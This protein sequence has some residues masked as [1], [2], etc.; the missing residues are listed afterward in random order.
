MVK[1][2]PPFNKEQAPRSSKGAYAV[3]VTKRGIVVKKWP[4]KRG[5]STTG[6]DMWR[7]QELA[8]AGSWATNPEPISLVSAIALAKNTDYVPRDILLLAMFGL[9]FEF[10]RI[11]EFHLVPA[12]Y[13]NPNPQY[14]LDMISDVPGAILR[15]DP[16]GW[17]ALLPGVDGEVLSMIEGFPN[18]IPQQAPEAAPLLLASPW[19]GLPNAL[20]LT[21]STSI[22]IT[23]GPGHIISALRAALTGDVTAPSNSNATTIGN[24]V[25]TYA[26][27]QNIGTSQRLLGR[28]AAGP[29]TIEELTL[30]DALDLAGAASQGSL[31]YRD[32]STWQSLGPGTLGQALITQGAGQNPHWATPAS[33]GGIDIQ[34][35]LTPG[36]FTGVSGWNK[37]AGARL[38]EVWVV[39]AGGGGGAGRRGPTTENSA[40]G[41]GGGSAGITWTKF[42]AAALPIAVDVTVGAGGAGGVTQ[43]TNATNGA[44]G[45]PGGDSYFGVRAASA[46]YLVG[47]AGQGG[48]GG[49]TAIASG[50]AGGNGRTAGFTGGSG[51]NVSTGSAPGTTNVLSPT[52]GGGG[53][54]AL[55]TSRGTR[56]GGAGGGY[57]TA[58]GFFSSG[59]TNTTAA[60]GIGSTKTA[61]QNGN[62]TWYEI[63]MGQGGGGGWF[64]NDG[65]GGNGGAGAQGGGG[66]GGGGPSNNGT[67]SGSGGNGGDGAVIVI[68]YM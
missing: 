38:V 59:H 13:D 5:P 32:A 66:G 8:W 12:R 2:R 45:L 11:P 30:T 41:G 17:V 15:R 36:T 55:A 52:A 27:I 22:T 43:T 56:D 19:A 31:L 16:I 63:I 37:P 50:G 3:H 49:T 23:T 35:F 1:V 40:G 60:G 21:G 62:A 18:W 7:Q 24:Q 67:N 26:K 10:S 47:T 64:N 14:I 44:P 9:L 46:Y 25:V 65:T 61:A 20:V 48:S 29:G 39:G 54:G 33:T 34:S 53:A 68:T 28:K 57:S 58:P 6:Y 42:P 51:N 4:R